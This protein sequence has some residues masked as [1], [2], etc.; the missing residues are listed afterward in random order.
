M[1]NTSI[2]EVVIGLVFVYLLLSLICTAAQEVIEGWLKKRAKDLETGIRALLHNPKGEGLA[3]HVYEHP[4]IFG[5]YSGNYA[6]TTWKEFFRSGGRTNLPSYIPGSNFAVALLDVVLHPD[7]VPS[8][9][10]SDAPVSDPTS[11]TPSQGT[12]SLSIR[13]IIGKVENV[14]VRRA[15]LALAEAAGDDENRLRAGVAA[16]FDSQMDRVSGWY[17]RWS[18]VV[19]LIL[20]LALTI[21]LNVDTITIC[22]ALAQDPRLRQQV[23]N[24][25]EQYNEQQKQAE[26]EKKPQPP[27]GQAAEAAPDVETA[28]KKLKEELDRLSVLG[29]P[30]GWNA[31][32]PRVHPGTNASGWASKIVGWLLTAFAISLGSP[33]W[34][35]LLNKFMIVRSTVKPIEKSPPEKPIS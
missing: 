28:R 30:I 19:I 9:V 33:F 34:F 6:P 22:A 4:L 32:D 23:V 27:P 21:G 35:D 16:W 25:A 31:N 29:L 14:Q 8:K 10:T 5:L 11:A 24:A 3:K 1:F 7:R 26:Q 17:K 13:E 15:L 12:S 18:E 20:G 2:F